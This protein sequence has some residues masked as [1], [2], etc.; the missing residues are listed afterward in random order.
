M[1]NNKQVQLENQLTA[2]EYENFIDGGYFIVK[3]AISEEKLDV[4]EKR[5]D[6]IDADVRKMGWDEYRNREIGP[7]N[8]L[9]YPDFIPKSG[10]FIELLDNP[11]VFPKV[12]GLLGWNI[13]LYYSDLVVTPPSPVVPMDKK[14]VADDW[15]QDSGRVNQEIFNGTHIKFFD[16]TV[17]RL[18]LKVGYF[19]SDCSKPDRGNMCVVDGS[20]LWNFDRVK[21]E[22]Q[23]E[24]YMTPILAER[25]DAV[26]F[27]RRLWHSRSEN[28]SDITRKVLF[29]GYAYR[30]MQGHIYN[31]IVLM[32]VYEDLLEDYQIRQ[33]LLGMGLTA[34][35]AYYPE[36]NDVPLRKTLAELS[37]DGNIVY[38][39]K[40]LHEEQRELVDVR[41]LVENV[42]K[43]LKT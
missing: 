6:Q 43:D 3:N 7:H 14:I 19:L 40:P 31:S 13:Y 4:I 2:E 39:E 34:D 20:Q 10:F 32:S 28:Y 33:Q 35:N 22:G 26:V 8:N 42:K 36:D 5:M 25:G 29:Y 38:W 18:S 12:Y 17:P 16:P 15:H 21:S 1:I 24:S 41:K 9:I 30:W 27:D 11:K 37:K 23:W